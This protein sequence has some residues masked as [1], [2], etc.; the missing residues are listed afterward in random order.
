MWK[1]AAYSLRHR[2]ASGPSSSFRTLTSLQPR[3]LLSTAPARP[4]IDLASDILTPHYEVTQTDLEETLEAPAHYATQRS[5]LASDIL[6]PHLAENVS[7]EPGVD[8]RR[9]SVLMQLTDRVG[10]LHDVLRYVRNQS[11]EIFRKLV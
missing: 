9:I 6:A 4:G 5:D 11:D 2:V 3:R 8:P 7:S 1:S 10:V